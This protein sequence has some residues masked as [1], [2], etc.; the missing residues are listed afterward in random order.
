MEPWTVPRDSGAYPKEAPHAVAYR[1]HLGVG[2]V[3]GPDSPSATW[4]AFLGEANHL[5]YKES[6]K[7]TPPSC[8][9]L[10]A[11]LSWGKFTQLC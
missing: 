7:G 2:V 6:E 3:M 1:V 4:S 11:K 5:V 8:S 9:S 10:N